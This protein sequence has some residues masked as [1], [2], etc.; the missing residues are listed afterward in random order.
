MLAHQSKQRFDPGMQLARAGIGLEGNI[1]KMEPVEVLQQLQ[2]R[3]GAERETKTARSSNARFGPMS[4][5]SVASKANTPL[6]AAEL[7]ARCRAVAPSARP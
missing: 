4:P 3:F 5:C 7:K 1:E 6:R 2:L